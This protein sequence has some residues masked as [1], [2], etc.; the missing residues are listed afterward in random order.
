MDIK[1]YI[2]SGLIENYVLGLASEEENAEINRLRDNYPEIDIA[3]DSFASNLELY[4]SSSSIA[5]PAYIK[6]RIFESLKQENTYNGRYV[7]NEKEEQLQTPVITLK[8]NIFT[9]KW[10][11]A[12]SFLLL[13]L[14]SVFNFLLYNRYVD[15]YDAYQALLSEKNSLSATNKIFQAS[16]KEWE[17][18][19]KMMSDPSMVMIRMKTTAGKNNKDATV[20]WNSKSKDV[21]VVANELPHPEM[22]KQFQL[23]AIVDGK[24]V[25]AGII[26]TNCTGICKMKNII[27][28]QAFAI[29]LEKSGGNPN[30]TMEQLMV[31]GAI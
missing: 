26:D 2:E 28:A 17:L 19:S 12:A 15:K 9:W 27:K 4:L 10:I 13:M 20:F 14:S 25:D 22:G 1:A 5:P 24:P 8:K 16:Q 6:E 11:A 23:W 29:T 31:M 21:Y 18:A 3:I 7:H 30:P